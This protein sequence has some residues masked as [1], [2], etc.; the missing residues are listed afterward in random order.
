[1][2]A[3]LDVKDANNQDP[4]MRIR[5]ATNAD[6]EAILELNAFVQRQHAEA[7]PELFKAPTKSRQT[8]ELF[9]GFLAD[10]NSLMILA[11][12]EQ[13]AGYLWAQFQDRPDS[14][15][16]QSLRLLCVQHMAVAPQFQGRGVGTLLMKKAV[17]TARSKGIH[18][19]EL[20]VWSFNSDAKRFYT[21]HGFKVFNERMALNV[22]EV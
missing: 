8:A 7:L 20:D 22:D 3:F 13:P 19:I 6:L 14:W 4:D 16:H 21:R 17:E 9:R 10:A 1:V 5:N 2:L 12:A 11:E 18:R 15:A